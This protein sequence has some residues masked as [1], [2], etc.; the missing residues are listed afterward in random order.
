MNPLPLWATDAEPSSPASSSP[1]APVGSVPAH[2]EAAVWKANEFGTPLTAVL[3]SGWSSL[4][5][6][7]PGGGWP[8]RSLTEVLQPQ[9][10]VCEWRLLGPALRSVVAAGQHVVVVGPP[11]RPHM[12]GLRHAGLDEKHFVWVQAETPAERLWVTEQLVKSNAAGALLAWLPQARAEQI[13]R[14]QVCAQACDGPAFLFR[15]DTARHEASAA[16]LRLTATFGLDWELLVHVLKRKGPR[17]EGVIRL[18]SVP[19]GLETV[20]TPRLKRPS[21]LISHR[22]VRPDVLGSTPARQALRRRVA[23]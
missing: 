8:C 16:P 6:E 7:L 22:E 17:H 12:P 5:A 20:L 15:P 1:R 10:S 23:A 21:R 9:P 2:L 4:D 18:E 11:K 14:L 13:R 3:K 19:G